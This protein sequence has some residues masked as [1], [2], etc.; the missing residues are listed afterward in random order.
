M[1]SLETTLHC[2]AKSVIAEAKSVLTPGVAVFRGGTIRPPR[3][4]K[5]NSAQVEVRQ[6]K[7][8]IDV[9]LL[10]NNFRLAIEIRVSHAVDVYKKQYFI[11]QG[12]AAIEIDVASIYQELLATRQ[13]D[14]LSALRRAILQHPTHRKWLFSPFQHRWE[15]RLAKEA[16]PLKVVI[17]Q[18]VNYHHYH[19]YHCPL[20][21]RFVRGGFRDGQS[22]ARVFQDCL[23]CQHCR[24]IVYEKKWVGFQRIPVLPQQVLCHG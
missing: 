1:G 24:E 8:Q 2:Y 3:W 10:G 23:H 17:S 12:I 4:A 21:L 20:N 16:Q 22:Y 6:D 9:L 13:A 19:V 18:H 15:Y 7:F 5:G 11:R 14:N